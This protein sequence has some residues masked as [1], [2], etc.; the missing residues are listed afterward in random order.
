MTLLIAGGDSFTWGSEL[1]DCKQ[2]KAS[3]M[4][5]S[6]LLSKQNEWEYRCVAK[7][8]CG[9]TAIA[10]RIMDATRYCDSDT[11]VT[12]MWSFPARYE[13]KIDPKIAKE[14]SKIYHNTDL[15]GEWL[16][17]ST[18]QTLALSEKKKLLGCGEDPVFNFRVERQHEDYDKYGIT[19]LAKSYYNLVSHEK[20]VNDTLVSIYTLQNYLKDRGLRYSFSSVTE[21][22]YDIINIDHPLNVMIDRSHWAGK[23]GM[24]DWAK[25]K[26]FLI[27]PMGH[28][29]P[30]A[31]IAWIEEHEIL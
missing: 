7:P 8:G 1:P 25:T 11:V 31:H 29:G 12:V 10:R 16:T 19:E 21:E 28:P 24:L 15:D 14:M 6:A 9:N 18:W 23:T 20:H 26:G 22:V 27:S 30:E 5:W 17:I 2:T 3:N 13:I 4:S